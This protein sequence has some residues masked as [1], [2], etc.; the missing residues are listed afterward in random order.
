MCRFPSGLRS[1]SDAGFTR[2]GLSMH[3]YRRLRDEGWTE[4][5]LRQVL[6]DHEV[7]VA[8]VE[9]IFG[10]RSHGPLHLEFNTLIRTT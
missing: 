3:E 10:L 8:E 6:D 4:A 9:A 5:A 2:I 7:C 1:A